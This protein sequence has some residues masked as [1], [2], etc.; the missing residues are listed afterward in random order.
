MQW[1][2]SMVNWTAFRSPWKHISG[3]PLKVLLKD[4]NSKED[5]SCMCIVSWTGI[6][7]RIK[8][9]STPLYFPVCR[10][11]Y[12]SQRCLCSLNA[13]LLAL[14]DCIP[15]NCDLKTKIKISSPTQI[16]VLLYLVTTTRKND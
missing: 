3:V 13:C 4:L 14:M 1:L 9:V 12:S 15:S 10:H 7:S 16:T 2:I 11:R 8:P 5:V 6:L